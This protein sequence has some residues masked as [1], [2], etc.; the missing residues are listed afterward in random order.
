M[1]PSEEQT[2]TDTSVFA[3]ERG[4]GVTKFMAVWVISEREIKSE[5]GG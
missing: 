5:K 1:P 3:C 2:T 4:Q